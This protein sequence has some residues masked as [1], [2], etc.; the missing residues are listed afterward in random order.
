MFYAGWIIFGLG[1]LS[2]VAAIRTGVSSKQAY[3]EGEDDHEPSAIFAFC[4]IAFIFVGM[5]MV[6]TAHGVDLTQ[7]PPRTR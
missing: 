7:P 5:G 6:L 1:V 4:A 2:L 3:P